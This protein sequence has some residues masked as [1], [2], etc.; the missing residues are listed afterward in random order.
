ML[1]S[2]CKSLPSEFPTFK[3]EPSAKTTPFQT[4]KWFKRHISILFLSGKVYLYDAGYY[5]NVSRDDLA[6]LVMNYCNKAI[7]KAGKPQFVNDV[8]DFIYKDPS[9]LISEENVPW[10]LLSFENGV[11]DID[12]GS[13]YRHSPSFLT[14]YGIHGKLLDVSDAY[15]LFCK[16]S[17][18]VERGTFAQ[19]FNKFTLEIFDV[20][21][22]RKRRPGSK[23]PQY[24]LSGIIFKGGN[25]DEPKHFNLRQDI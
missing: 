11:F 17:G 23:N 14:F 19:F 10:N 8:V 25:N 18:P 15:T 12:S 24:A 16:T 22:T 3:T 20:K 4:F 1:P 6:R 5:K 13:L 2:K 9:I 21:R 7:E